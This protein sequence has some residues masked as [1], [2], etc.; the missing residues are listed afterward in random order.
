MTL[1]NRLSLPAMVGRQPHWLAQLPEARNAF[2]YDD[3]QRGQFAVNGVPKSWPTADDSFAR[4]GAAYQE[5]AS[6]LLVSKPAGAP[7]WPD[8]S[9]TPAGL[10]MEGSVTNQ[11]ENYNANPTDLTGVTKG[12]DAAATLTV[13]DDA[14][15]IAAAGLGD[16]CTSGLVYK[17]D[18]SAGSGTA[19]AIIACDAV[20]TTDEYTASAYVRCGAGSG[21]ISFIFQSDGIDFSNSGY[22]RVSFSDTPSATTR[23]MGIR[24]FA[25]AVVYFIL[26]QFEKGS[27]ATSPIVVTGGSSTRN[28]D[29]LTRDVSMFDLSG[30][31]WVFFEG[32]LN[33]A[34]GAFDRIFQAG[35]NN[36]R[37]SLEYDAATSSFAARQFSGGV[38]AGEVLSA[39]PL[40]YSG[41]MAAR[42][43]SGADM[44][45]L[46]V[47][48]A[49]AGTDTTSAYSPATSVSIAGNLSGG[50]KP[51][52]LALA[53]LWVTPASAYTIADAEAKTA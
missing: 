26:N 29:A 36:I 43:G 12:G 24:A 49:S 31:I 45:A 1:A 22:E 40:G 48:G 32:R 42:F 25:G 52:S 7:R 41:K 35:A 8:Y 39:S 38:S 9:N 10:L 16:I 3:W 53:R 30:G 34:A 47:D 14:A 21:D 17:L 2:F 33:A 6:G 19:T 20:T 28:A 11:C 46:V 37:S 51:A 23:D 13:V 4:A 5:L 15:E 44:L 18:N 27:I 50:D